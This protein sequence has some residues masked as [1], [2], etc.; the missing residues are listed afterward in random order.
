MRVRSR[1]RTAGPRRCQRPTGAAG[2]AGL[3]GP[4]G[5]AGP[6]DLRLIPCSYGLLRRRGAVPGPGLVPLPS[7]GPY[8]A[9]PGDRTDRETAEDDQRHHLAE[10]DA[11]EE[12]GAGQVGGPDSLPGIR[13]VLR[14]AD[15][16]PHRLRGVG[17]VQ[18]AR[19]VAMCEE[20][21]QS[22]SRPRQERH[23]EQEADQGYQ[24]P[25]RDATA[26]TGAP[27][28]PAW[29][30]RRAGP[31]AAWVAAWVD[32]HRPMPPRRR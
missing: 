18:V 8:G 28:L 19:P 4:A 9:E 6:A 10:E 25:I 27:P 12:P 30:A 21:G 26:L 23:A 11:P 2:P 24:Q 1:S 7:R 22:S 31:A 20:A 3:A 16:L 29:G 14:I 15:Q 32:V 13:H 17:E 5:R